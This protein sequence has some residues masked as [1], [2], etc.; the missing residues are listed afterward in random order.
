[1]LHRVL[2]NPLKSR[3]SIASLHSLP[4]GSMVRPSPKLIDDA[5][6]RRYKD[7]DFASFIEYIA[8]HEHRSKNFLDSRR[9]T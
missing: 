2:V 7:T 9:L 1:V 6:P 4:F 5:N 3:I 8:S